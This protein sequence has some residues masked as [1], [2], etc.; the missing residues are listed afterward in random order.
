MRCEKNTA[1]TPLKS[2]TCTD[3]FYIRT[4][5]REPIC[6]DMHVMAADSR[7][8]VRIATAALEA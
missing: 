7:M 6:I 4:G 3:A 8:P 2:E 5:V 1:E